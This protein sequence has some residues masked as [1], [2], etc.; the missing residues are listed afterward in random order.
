MDSGNHSN[1][2]LP[3]QIIE[4]VILDAQAANTNRFPM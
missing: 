4:E 1:V 2:T 3:T